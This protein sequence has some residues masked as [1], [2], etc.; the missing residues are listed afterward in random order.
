MQDDLEVDE[1]RVV[2]PGVTVARRTFAF[3]ALGLMAAA[4]PIGA[5]RARAQK[6]ARASLTFEEFLA[7]AKPLAAALIG[8]TSLTGQSRYLLSMAALAT[9]L[10][11]VPIPEM[12]DTRQGETPGT[13]IGFNPG[14]DPF[15]VLHWRLE[16]GARVRPHAHTYGN[17]VTLGLAGE[18]Y[19]ENFEVIG[20]RDFTS[21]HEFEVRRTQAQLLTAGAVNLVNLQRDYIHGTAAGPAGARGLDITTRIATKTP[22]PYLMISARADRSAV[23]RATWSIDDPRPGDMLK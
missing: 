3:T 17:V 23:F 4:L 6:L 5:Q 11:D 8:D 15:T 16:P 19:V 1:E 7:E 13:F 2:A 21:A 14:G 10:S 12:N 20:E 9:R 22:T 18:A